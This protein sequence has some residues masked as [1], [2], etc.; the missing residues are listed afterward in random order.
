MLCIRAIYCIGAP[1][2]NTEKGN[3]FIGCEIKF[4]GDY[5]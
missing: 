4:Y 5:E 2:R 1:T 3:L